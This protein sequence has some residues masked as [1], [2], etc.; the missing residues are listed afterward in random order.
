LKGGKEKAS[1]P[2]VTLLQQLFY[3]AFVQLPLARVNQKD[4]PEKAAARSN[5]P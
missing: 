3:H 4:T 1:C 5:G 2:M